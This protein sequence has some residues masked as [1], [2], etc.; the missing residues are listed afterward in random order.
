MSDD[1]MRSAKRRRKSLGGVVHQSHSPR[2]KFLL[3]WW[4]VVGRRCKAEAHAVELSILHVV[5]AHEH[6]AIKGLKGCGRQRHHGWPHRAG[7]WLRE[8]ARC[9]TSRRSCQSRRPVANLVDAA[10]SASPGATAS[11]RR[12]RRRHR[13][14]SGV[15][16]GAPV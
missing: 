16:A 5:R 2:Q 11:N 15:A 12:H 7:S 4:H 8:K 1:Q 10:A 14:T 9:R 6:V 13:S 3:A